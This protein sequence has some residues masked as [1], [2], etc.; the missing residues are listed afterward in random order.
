LLLDK[1]GER[2]AFERKGI[3]LYECLI[4]KVRLL[5][6][7]PGGPGI[8]ELEHILEEERQHFKFLQKAVVRFGG[9]WTRDAERGNQCWRHKQEQR[10]GSASQRSGKAQTRSSRAH[11]RAGAVRDIVSDDCHV[12]PPGA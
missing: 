9:G 4:G 7:G 1:L 6:G 12:F 2:L 3:R 5:G 8:E 10:D 11:T